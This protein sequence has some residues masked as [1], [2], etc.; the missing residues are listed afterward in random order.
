MKHLDSLGNVANFKTVFIYF[1]LFTSLS[2]PDLY[3]G[4]NDS[5]KM[6]LWIEGVLSVG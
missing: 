2:Q 3:I 6:D 1:A 5:S 4:Y